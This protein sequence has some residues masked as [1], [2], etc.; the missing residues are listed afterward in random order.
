[1]GFHRPIQAFRF[2]N[3]PF[4]PIHRRAQALFHPSLP[5]AFDRT[6]SDTIRSLNLGVI[7]CLFTMFIGGEQDIGSLDLN[8][9]CIA[10]FDQMMSLSTFIV[11]Q[12]HAVFLRHAPPPR[13]SGHRA[14]II[15]VSTSKGMT[16]FQRFF[17]QSFF[18]DNTSIK[19]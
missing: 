4:F 12:R 5:D 15:P 17:S 8:G 3:L 14:Q 2:K 9:F 1:M 16:K 6:P 18:S 7:P 10:F 19:Y 13:F 11:S